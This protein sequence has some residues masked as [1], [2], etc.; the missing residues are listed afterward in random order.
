MSFP[1]RFIAGHDYWRYRGGDWE[2][3]QVYSGAS[4]KGDL[5]ISNALISLGRKLGTIKF[6]EWH[7]EESSRFPT[8]SIGGS[9]SEENDLNLILFGNISPRMNYPKIHPN[10]ES[11]EI[12]LAAIKSEL[13][14]HF[15]NSSTSTFTFYGS[16]EAEESTKITYLDADATSDN[17]PTLETGLETAET[18]TTWTFN[19]MLPS[20]KI[21]PYFLI[22]GKNDE[23][24]DV[25]ISKVHNLDD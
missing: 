22:K 20:Y 1:L 23:S 6:N 10:D 13:Y 4:F 3:A 14:G 24:K 11:Y 16:T 15:Y 5:Y 2:S 17:Q 21:H 19:S 9:I 18:T 12:E 25:Y 8:F 7:G